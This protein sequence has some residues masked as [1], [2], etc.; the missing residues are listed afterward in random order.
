MD[1][2]T[3]KFAIS[4][5]VTKENGD[6]D[7]EVTYPKG[8]MVFKNTYNTPD[9][10]NPGTGDGTPLFLLLGLLLCSGGALAAMLIFRKRRNSHE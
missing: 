3:T 8:G 9:P 4:V 2:D 10:K 7:A 1:Y 6:L 5:K